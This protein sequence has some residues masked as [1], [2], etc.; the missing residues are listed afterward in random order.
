MMES[1]RMHRCPEPRSIVASVASSREMLL[2]FAAACVP[3]GASAPGIAAQEIRPAAIDSVFAHYDNTRVPGCAVG[4]IVG[5]DLAFAR[6]YGMADLEHGVPLDSRSVF[7]IG[8][9]SKQFSAAATILLAQDGV[10]SLD[11]PVR[12]WIPEHPDFGPRFTIRRLINHTSGVRDY[13][14]LMSLAGYRD[15]DWYSDD[16]VVAMLARQTAPNFEPG[17]DHLYSNSGYFLLSQIVKRAT[18]KTLAEYAA[19]RMFKPLGMRDTHFHD[20][21]TR[22]VPR[23]AIGHAPT[24]DGGFRISTTTLPMIGDGGIFTSIEDL[25]A[26]DRNLDAGATVGGPAFVTEMHRRGIRNDGD[27][28]AYASGLVHGTHR[29][30]RIVEHGGAFVGFRAASLRYPDEGVSIYT[31]CNRADAN[32]SRLSLAVGEAVLGERMETADASSSTT[33]PAPSRVDT[34]PVTPRAAAAY[35]GTYHAPELDARYVISADGSELALEVGNWL[36][37][38]LVRTGDDV[39]RRGSLTLRFERSGGRVTGFLLDAGRV[40]GIRF[41]RVD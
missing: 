27:T 21:P 37:G 32:P 38:S 23:R 33:R 4:V 8:S 40:R 29:G 35:A 22:I 25:V 9:V 36:D 31:L 26:W 10:I 30:L 1:P 7:R 3:L 41:R 14:T 5:D 16:D 6:G 11:D 34:L 13:L 39:F 28:L 2:M 17:S 24:D 15:D 12:R 18:G 19:E 20:D